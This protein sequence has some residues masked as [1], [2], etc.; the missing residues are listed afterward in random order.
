VVKMNKKRI[1]VIVIIAI[2][3]VAAGIY[4]IPH[5][6]YKPIEKVTGTD[7]SKVDKVVIGA[8]WNGNV[9]TLTDKDEIDEFLS[10]FK[11]VKVRKNFDQRSR[12]GFSYSVMLFENGKEV[13]GFT[14]LGPGGFYMR[15]KYYSGKNFDEDK[16]DKIDTSYNWTRED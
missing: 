13:E 4:L 2:V 12:T 3:L 6:V 9:C 11:D 15:G 10:L 1:A 16:L 14:V 8:G 7:F 5:L